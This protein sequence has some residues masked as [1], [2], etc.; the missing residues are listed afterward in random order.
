M[1]AVWIAG[2]GVFSAIVGPLLLSWLNTKNTIALKQADWDRMDR[3]AEVAKQTAKEA[4]DAARDA[5]DAVIKVADDL[6]ESQSV[7]NTGLEQVAKVA[8][9]GQDGVNS[10]L[11]QIHTLVNSNLTAAMRGE[12][13]AVQSNL[14][15]LRKLEGLNPA[16]T[17]D[18]LAAIKTLENRERE[19]SDTLTERMEQQRIIDQMATEGMA[20]I[21]VTGPVTGV[22]PGGVPE[23]PELPKDPGLIREEGDVE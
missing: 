2:I 17:P 8:K 20:T 19:L 13:T 9:E 10:Q 16:S 1:E 14:L 22:V 21:Q 4:S 5:S 7:L 12:L 23:V 6:K 11:K 18:E 3:V 15:A